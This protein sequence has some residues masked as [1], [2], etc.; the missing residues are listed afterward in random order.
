MATFEPL[1]QTNTSAMKS[2]SILPLFIISLVPAMLLLWSCASVGNPSGGPRD[3]DPPVPV[4]INP[5]P[6]SVNFSGRRI[7]IDFNEL[8]NV[9][10]AFTK[11]TVSPTSKETPRVS[12]SGH[13]V[14]VQFA[15][16]LLPNT[17][18]TIDFGNS[19]EDNNEGNKL[20]GFSLSFSTGPEL[21]S[22]RIS[23]IVL[24]SRD[25]EPRQEML[26]G[27][28]SNPEDSAF[29]TLPLERITK[30]DDR[31]RFT[32]R[33]LKPGK[34]RVYALGDLNN[35]Y[36]WDN[37]A[38]DIAFYDVIV[39]PSSEPAFASDSI[40]DPITHQFDSIANYSYTRFLPNDILLS[41]FNTNYKPQ[42]LTNNE[43]I[44]S[45]RISLI[46]NGRSEELPQISIVG[47]PQ[48]KDWYIL[49]KSRYNDTL[50][51]WIK[52][53]SLI[54]SDTLRIATRYLRTDSA[55]KLAYVNDTLRLITKRPQ[56]AN[57]KKKRKTSADSIANIKFLDMKIST[58]STHDIYNP[59]FIELETPPDTIFAEKF[60]LEEKIDTLWK[61]VA[62]TWQ[63]QRAD[64]LSVRKFKL[65]Y[66]W[67]YGKSYRIV[68][69]TIAVVGIYG[70]FTKPT[71]SE[72][73]IKKEEDY[74]NVR[75]IVQG[76]APTAPAFVELLNASDTP[77]RTEKVVG[78]AA[79]F[80][81]VNPGLYYARL[82]ED[83]NSNGE[84]DTGDFEK[85][86][87]PEAVWYYPKKINLKKNWDSDLTW[88]LN[89]IAL[90]VQ[91]PAELR[92][93]KYEDEKKRPKKKRSET[94]ED[95]E[96]DYFDPTANPFDPNQKKRRQR[97][98]GLAY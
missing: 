44:D 41:A 66:P 94:D 84:Y 30:T 52:D 50:T 68:A 57:K 5:I 65:D 97:S 58:S 67:E 47:A 87:Q 10:D 83:A 62:Q 35:D 53:R 38:E 79:I 91:K 8:V 82:V 37:P 36:R 70:T 54:L 27:I 74:A 1:N 81:N 75:F 23:G 42:Y 18:Y 89:A 15:D 26:V 61:P 11:V 51:Y 13:R 32:I 73:T 17:T 78:G 55:Q 24:N 7:T 28:H 34:Y 64:T 3:E 95:E 77:V 85:N 40:F 39:S 48:L 19:I 4:R 31:G 63:L 56:D 21:D 43:R 29:K 80:N 2:T 6:N 59:V 93:A 72:F 25:L 14:T 22:L 46:F 88:D 96:E 90:D 9:K 98:T 20:N 86:L 49:E 33:G 71:S 60:R 12:S 92:K 16:S 45:T 76:L 69:D